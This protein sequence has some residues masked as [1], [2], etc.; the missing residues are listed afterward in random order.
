MQIGRFLWPS[1]SPASCARFQWIGYRKT[2]LTA[3]SNAIGLQILFKPFDH[4]CLQVIGRLVAHVN[5]P[6]NA[7]GE[8][9]NLFHAQQDELWLAI[10]GDGG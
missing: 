1:V 6:E 5:L 4:Q 8:L 10:P 9:P 7:V 3:A 2:S